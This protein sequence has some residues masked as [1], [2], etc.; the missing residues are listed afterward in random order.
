MTTP[1]GSPPR[2]PREAGSL[3]AAVTRALAARIDAAE[4]RP[5]DRLPPNAS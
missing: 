4:L 2:P 1:A 5:G 3:P